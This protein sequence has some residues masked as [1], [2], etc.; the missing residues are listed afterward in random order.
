MS[1]LDDRIDRE[2]D[3]LIRWYKSWR[4][5][6]SFLL[7][8]SLVIFVLLIRSEYLHVFVHYVGQFGYLGAV[9]AGLFFVSTFTVAP[10]GVLLF[11]F[12][13]EL[14][15]LYAALAA[16]LGA[17][18]GDHIIFRIIKSGFLDELRPIFHR[19]GKTHFG[20]LISTPLFGWLA[21]IVGAV[22]IA[23]PLP[24]EVGIGLLG[25]SHMKHWQLLTIS[26]TLNAI[27]IFII[28]LLGTI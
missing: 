8:L 24:N 22:F 21:P 6:N 20:K 18:I 16:S 19:L 12:A 7:I 15:P 5:H 27:G 2:L 14:D 10:A 17:V 13:K 28:V 9:L 25:I 1:S 3:H 4:F 26:G 23:S 11:H